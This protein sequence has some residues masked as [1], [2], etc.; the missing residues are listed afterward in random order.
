MNMFIELQLARVQLHRFGAPAPCRGFVSTIGETPKWLGFFWF[1]FKPTQTQKGHTDVSST[2]HVSVSVCDLSQP[3]RSQ[4]IAK[5][6]AGKQ[7]APNPPRM[8]LSVLNFEHVD[9]M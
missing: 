4:F 3:V 1:P 6:K 2:L 7:R 5:Q 8:R 9:A